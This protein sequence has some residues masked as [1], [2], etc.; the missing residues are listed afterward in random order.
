MEQSDPFLNI[1]SRKLILTDMGASLSKL[2]P[3]WSYYDKTAAN[4]SRTPK[5]GYKFETCPYKEGRTLH[6]SPLYGL[7]TL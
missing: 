3:F 4:I 5:G 2:G 1:L 7:Y 6:L